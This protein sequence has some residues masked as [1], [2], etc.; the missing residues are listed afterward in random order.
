MVYLIGTDEAGYGPNLGPLV[1]SASVWQVPDG[2]R[3][4]DL[5][6][7]LG[8]VIVDSIAEAEKSRS[9]ARGHCRFK[10]S[11]SFRRRSA[12]FGART[13]GRLGAYWNINL[14]LG[15]RFGI[16]WQLMSR[17]NFALVPGSK[18]TMLPF[19]AMALLLIGLPTLCGCAI[20][21]RPK[22]YNCLHCGAGRFFR[23]SSINCWNCYGSKGALLSHLTLELIEQVNTTASQPGQSRSSA[24]NTAGGIATHPLLAE[25]FPDWM[26]EIH[27]E[28]RQQSVYRFGPAER[29]IEFCFRTNAERCLPAALASMASKYLRELAMQAFNE[30]WCSASRSLFPRPVILKTPGDL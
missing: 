19:P 7:R 22:E 3:S 26:I 27:G 11:L 13:V 15:A 30:Y 25:H 16:L 5:F 6:D 12:A 18:S 24:T 10:N 1:I 9:A 4:E 2:M 29:R 20:R 8:H 17:T 23:K 21:S 14:A 28:S